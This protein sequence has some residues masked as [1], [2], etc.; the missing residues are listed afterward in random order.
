[1]MSNGWNFDFTAANA[2]DNNAG[3]QC[4]LHKKWFG[5]SGGD[6]VGTL[7]ATMK[8][9][10]EATIDFGNCWNAGVV[11]LYLDDTK[12]ATASVGQKSIVFKF[13]YTH[14]SVLKLKDEE[15]N[16]IVSFNSIRFSCSNADGK[17]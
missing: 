8:G 4:A 15:G 7:S 1:M 2:T 3:N 13:S 12:L 11:N 5:Y 6:E 10:G 17:F 14:G 16:A 9:S